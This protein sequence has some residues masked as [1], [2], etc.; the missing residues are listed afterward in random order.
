MV[1]TWEEGGGVGNLVWGEV[2]WVFFVCVGGGG[3]GICGG[4]QMLLGGG[5]EGRE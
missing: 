3:R 4:D 1:F 5:M 2:M